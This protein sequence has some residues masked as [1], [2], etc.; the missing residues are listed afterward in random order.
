MLTST[1]KFKIALLLILTSVSQ[2]LTDGAKRLVQFETKANAAGARS[3]APIAM[4]HL[5]IPLEMVGV[6]FA[7]SIDPLIAQSLIYS[8]NGRNFVRWVLNPED[9]MWSDKVIQHFKAQG[10]RL[11]KQYY[12]TGYQTASRSYIVEDPANGSQFSV[13]S[14]TNV[15]GGSWRDKKQPIGEATDGRLLSDF[16]TAQN[17]LRTFES[18]V[19][20]EEPAIMSIQALDQAVVIRD[21]VDLK[22]KDGKFIYL[23]G[24]SALHEVVGKEIATRNGSSDPYKFWTENYVRVAG[25][26]LGELAGRTGIQFDSPH[27]QNFLIELDTK[28]KPTGRLVLRDMSDLYIDSSYFKALQGPDSEI[29]KK[30]T[31]TENVK[32]YT[33]AGFG[34]LHGNEK[35]SWVSEELY[36]KWKDI[37][38]AEYESSFE[39]VTGFSLSP[40]KASKDQNYDYFG[41]AY[42]VGGTEE[43]KPFFESLR[44]NGYVRNKSTETLC[45]QAL[46]QVAGL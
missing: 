23:P 31:Q 12:F 19:I 16:L 2:A 5:D 7:K 30:F 41:A 1:M 29:L 44:G 22:S 6:D 27:S 36:S 32:G 35:P 38:F 20:M 15:T 28:L 34:P 18:F 37:F 24:F 14:S 25:T 46:G 3:S 39:K 9:T 42:K 21:L 4:P 33:Q 17:R 11:Q 13:K 45:R 43:F 8:R 10:L 26:A 40:L